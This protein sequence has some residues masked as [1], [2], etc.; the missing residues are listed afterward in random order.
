MLKISTQNSILCKLPMFQPVFAVKG[1]IS[2]IDFHCSGEQ[3]A[4]AGEESR[5]SVG[6]NENRNGEKAGFVCFFSFYQI[7]CFIFPF[8][9]SVF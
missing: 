4:S 3:L 9:N 1:V 6:Q 5:H 7:G 8:T 2:S